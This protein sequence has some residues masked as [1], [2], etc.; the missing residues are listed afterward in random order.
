[1][2]SYDL[3]IQGEVTSTASIP[4]YPFGYG[5]AIAC[6]PVCLIYLCYLLRSLFKVFNR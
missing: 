3:Q 6:I 1:V 5:A 2:Y 4:F